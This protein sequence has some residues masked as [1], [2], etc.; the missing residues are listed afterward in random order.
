M[1]WA[2]CSSPLV[3]ASHGVPSGARLFASGCSSY[4]IKRRATCEGKTTLYG[5]FFSLVQSTTWDFWGLGVRTFPAPSHP[6]LPGRD[7]NAPPP[8]LA[9]TPARS[10]PVLGTNDFPRI[11]TVK[12]RQ[13]HRDPSRFYLGWSRNQFLTFTVFKLKAGISW[14]EESYVLR[15][16]CII[17]SKHD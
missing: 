14:F 5:G 12:R 1:M 2:R 9:R 10:H 17:N 11:D 6:T 15:C 3:F 16:I 13:P 7:R 4:S 8:P